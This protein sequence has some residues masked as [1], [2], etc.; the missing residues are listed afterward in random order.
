MSPRN[1]RHHHRTRNGRSDSG[2]GAS[3]TAESGG[4]LGGPG[5]PHEMLW[6]QIEDRIAEMVAEYTP[7][8]GTVVGQD[9]GAV[10]VQLDEEDDAREVGFAKKKGTR[11]DT[12]ERVLVGKTRGGR[13]VVLG[14]ITDKQGQAERAVANEDL[15]DDAVGRRNIQVDSVGPDELAGGA[16]DN[17]HLSGGSVTGDKIAGNSV[18]R[19]HIT[20]NA[21]GTN[22]IEGGGVKTNNIGD[23]QVTRGKLD[24][25]VTSDIQKGIDDAKDAKGDASKAQGT[26]DDAITKAK[27][28]QNT[29][30]KAKSDIAALTTRLKK[31]E[32]KVAKL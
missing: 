18:D 12:N 15:H 9:G 21:I 25:G 29:A 13:H 16:V 10:R 19:K 30:D 32:D 31:L 14:P 26:A 2:N 8:L 4:S 3:D 11:Y 20:N 17:S 27:D 22:Q 23:N 7:T 28:A 1:H 6:Q 24:N 5:S